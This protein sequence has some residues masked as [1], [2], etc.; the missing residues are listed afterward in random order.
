MFQIPFG[1]WTVMTAAV[2]TAIRTAAAN[3]GEQ[4]EGQQRPAEELR[5]AGGSGVQPAGAEADVVEHAGGAVEAA[6]AEGAEE[7]LGAMSD[8]EDTHDNAESEQCEIHADP[9]LGSKFEV[10]RSY[11]PAQVLFETI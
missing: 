7:L 4:A 3:G 2:I 9:S 6:T 10:S 8:E 5:R 1:A 11:L